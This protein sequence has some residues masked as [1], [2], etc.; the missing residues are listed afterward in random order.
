MTLS[1]IIFQN[2]LIKTKDLIILDEPTYGFSRDQ[3]KNVRN[4]FQYLNASQIIVVSHEPE[5]E[6]FVDYVIHI[7]KK[8][9]VSHYPPAL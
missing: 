8:N 3:L 7:E 2:F 4:V 1:P 9:N 5:V 6:G